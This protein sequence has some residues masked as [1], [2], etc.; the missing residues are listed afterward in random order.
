MK[1]MGG[2]ANLK[3]VKCNKVDRATKSEAMEPSFSLDTAVFMYFPFAFIHG[4]RLFHYLPYIR[5]RIR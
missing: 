5:S 4:A 3:L 1:K 2:L